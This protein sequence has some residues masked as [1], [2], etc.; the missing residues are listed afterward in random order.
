MKSPCQITTSIN[1]RLDGSLTVLEIDTD[2]SF[3]KHCDIE[4]PD[5]L[6]PEKIGAL[7]LSGQIEVPEECSKL[8]VRKSGDTVA[9]SKPADV[10]DMM[11]R[12]NG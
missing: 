5:H 1:I 8:I 6:E 4:N 12:I 11:E 10:I 3:I 9:V 2:G 7:Y